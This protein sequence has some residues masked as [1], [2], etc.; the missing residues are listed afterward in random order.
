MGTML[1]G[2]CEGGC[3][4]CQAASYRID[5]PR[6]R[7]GEAH[8]ADLTVPML[9]GGMVLGQEPKAGVRRLRHRLMAGLML[10]DEGTRR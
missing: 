8:E 6:P 10:P 5:A 7:S 3:G 9:V 1:N 4:R 2:D